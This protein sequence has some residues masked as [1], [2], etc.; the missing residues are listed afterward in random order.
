MVLTGKRT[1]VGFGFGPIQAGLF[2]YE[3]FRSGNFGRLVAAEVR[4]EV[5]D[6]VA[7]AGGRYPV[8]V[9]HSDRIETVW[10]EPLEIVN[11][12]LKPGRRLMSEAIAG[13]DEI[14][15]AV[16]SIHHYISDGP[17]SIHRI[18][19]EGLRLKA[20]RGGP[21]AVIYA[22]E[23]NNRAAE[24]LEEAVLREVPSAERPGVS[25]HIRY[26][27]TVIGKM[28]GAVDAAGDRRLPPIAAG[29]G[30]AFLVEAFNRILISQIRF[31]APS[32]GRGITCFLEKPDLLP[33]E[34]AKL[35]GHNATHALA[36][37][38][39]AL[40]GMRWIAELRDCHEIMSF[41]REAFVEESGKALVRRHAG[42]D[43]L[44]TPEGYIE[45]AD[46][47]L[48]RMVN[49]YLQDSTERVGR[50]PARKLAWD[51]RLVG[52]MRVALREGVTPR[53]YAVGAAAALVVMDPA[54]LEE[55]RSAA[56]WLDPIWNEA[57]PDPGERQAVLNLIEEGR[58]ALRRWLLLGHGLRG[59]HGSAS[60]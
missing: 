10:V 43:P 46:D 16:P 34:E 25:S 7:R 15:T 40:R 38:L 48:A 20:A 12:V 37:Y 35:Y 49:P 2:L 3:S 41:L 5:V 57:A 17:G 14:A 33:F 59:L 50:D 30:T 54:A 52:T 24:I 21:P 26:L 9:A 45:Y 58:G 8:N 47:L 27:N 11:P 55:G 56:S 23:N 18:L 53:R 19:A 22:A 44:F 6:A 28:S 60:V 39:A 13:A 1:F 51:D 36:A 29:L 4:P 42:I 31:T 32:F